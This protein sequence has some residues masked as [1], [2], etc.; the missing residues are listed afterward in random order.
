MVV[1]GQIDVFP[2]ERRQMR[3]VNRCRRVPLLAY[4]IDG[5]L[6]VHGVPQNDCGDEQVQA[7]GTMKLVFIG[8]V[9]NLAKW[10]TCFPSIRNRY[11]C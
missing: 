9:A 5:A 10:R 7:A 1:S 4:V 6:Q 8:T 2:A 3:K 11:C